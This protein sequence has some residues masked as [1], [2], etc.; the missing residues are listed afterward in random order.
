MILINQIAPPSSSLEYAAL[1]VQIVNDPNGTIITLSVHTTARAPDDAAD[2]LAYP[3]YFT[4]GL[5]SGSPN[6]TQNRVIEPQSFSC[7]DN[8]IHSEAEWQD[9]DA[10]RESE[11]TSSL[12]DAYLSDLNGLPFMDALEYLMTNPKYGD[13]DSSLGDVPESYPS[14]PNSSLPHA[15]LKPS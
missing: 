8:R 1:G 13:T 15:D 12:L 10:L 11:N 6:E 5:E 14:T 3:S 4:D 2:K 7:P 9:A